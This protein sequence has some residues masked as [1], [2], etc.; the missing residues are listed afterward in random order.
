MAR[1]SQAGLYRPLAHGFDERREQ[2]YGGRNADPISAAVPLTAGDRAAIDT[3]LRQARFVD[4][5]YPAQ[6]RQRIDDGSA[7]DG[8]SG[9]N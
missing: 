5:R 6:S 7:I 9:T 2:R 3:A 4:A 8:R 1:G